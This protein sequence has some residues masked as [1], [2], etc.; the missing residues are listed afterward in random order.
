MQSFEPE[1]GEPSAIFKLGHGYRGVAWLDVQHFPFCRIWVLSILKISLI[2]EKFFQFI[3]SLI[4]VMPASRKMPKGIKTFALIR[5]CFANPLLQGLR[6]FAGYQDWF[7][8][9]SQIYLSQSSSK[10]VM[11]DKTTKSSAFDN[12]NKAQGLLASCRRWIL[13]DKAK[14]IWD[15]RW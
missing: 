3:K 12:R 9:G 14:N 10:S 4:E 7:D 15:V 2:L 11:L 8:P 6:R 5:R 1:Y 13:G